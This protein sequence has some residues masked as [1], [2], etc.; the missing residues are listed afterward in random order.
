MSS[1]H[2]REESYNTHGM[3]SILSV[4]ISRHRFVIKPYY[5]YVTSWAHTG[6]LVR[7]LK[8]FGYVKEKY[9]MGK[10]IDIKVSLYFK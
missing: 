5:S 7:Y 8:Q 10:F 6:Y 4:F 9:T 2:R 1:K 3:R